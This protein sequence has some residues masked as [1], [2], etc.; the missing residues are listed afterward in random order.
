MDKI[1][2]KKRQLTIKTFF[3]VSIFLFFFVLC[4]DGTNSQ[5]INVSILSVVMSI[6]LLLLKGGSS[7]LRKIFTPAN[8]WCAIFLLLAALS[9]IQSINVQ[10]SMS[11]TVVMLKKLIVIFSIFI[12]IE[13]KEDWELL[14]KLYMF[15][16]LLMMVKITYYALR[17][18]NGIDM[19][20]IA[21]GN[22]F[23]SVAQFLAI[24]IM[25]A[26]YF[27]MNYKSTR[28]INVFYILFSFYH[29]FLTGSRKGLLMPVVGIAIYIVLESGNKAKKHM[30]NIGII[31][32]AVVVILFVFARNP[33][34][35]ER[36]TQLFVGLFVN[37]QQQDVSTMMR[38]SFISIAMNMFR[39]KPI[40][41]YGVG[42]F[43][44][45]AQS[46]IGRY[47]Y[48]HNNFTEIL[49]GMGVIGFVGYYWYYIYLAI[50]LYCMKKKHNVYMICLSILLTLTVFEYGI[51][52]YS[53][54]IYPVILSILSI[55]LTESY[56]KS[57][58]TSTDCKD[59]A[60]K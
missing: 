18:Y 58:I 7:C 40:W 44:T 54:Y 30:R 48:S 45:V 23:N 22:Y 33:E 43:A 41:G 2:I 6:M 16:C 42:T 52:T 17:G 11:I 21:C 55:P 56:S 27:F 8:L 47:V 19:W 12:F 13:N 57:L 15:S 36:F 32:L 60:C 28:W 35:E 4:C 20:D 31:V 50:K 3:W 29:I 14:I 59:S 26:V 53:I 49:S 37:D 1:V 39:E 24:S 10:A 9:C 5:M 25:F 51:V 46:T 38:Q 34:L